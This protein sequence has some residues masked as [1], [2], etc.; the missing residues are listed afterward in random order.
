MID[1]HFDTDA[2]QL[3]VRDDGCGFDPQHHNGD[4]HFGLI[5]MRERAQEIGGELRILSE[6]LSG[7][8]IIVNVPLSNGDGR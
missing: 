7:T 4:G 3:R 5:G 6:R 2:L 1:L 8:E